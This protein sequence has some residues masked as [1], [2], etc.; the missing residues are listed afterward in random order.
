MLDAARIRF[1]GLT[2]SNSIISGLRGVPFYSG[3]V[4]LIY[5]RLR[6]LQALVDQTIDAYGTLSTEGQKLYQEHF[7][8]EKSQ[9]SSENPRRK[10]D[11]SF[12][13]PENAALQLY[14]PWHGKVKLAQFRIHFEW[15]RP[16]SQR[17]IKVVYVGP[18]ITKW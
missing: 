4:G 11:L 15:P 3:I 10:S 9:F 17:A 1:P 13:D 7:V 18:K 5:E 12:P 6:I 8:G 2:F 14:C 16:Q